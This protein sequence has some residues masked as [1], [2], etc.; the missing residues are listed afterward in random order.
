MGEGVLIGLPDIFFERDGELWCE[1]VSLS[2]IGREVGTPC[3]VYSETGIRRR[4]DALRSAFTGVPCRIFYSAKANANLAILR[5]LRS[6]GAGVDVVSQGELFRARCAGFQAR[7]IVFGGVGKTAQELGAGLEAEILL[8]NVESEGELRRL[9]GLAAARGARAPV[10]IR[11]NPGMAVDTHAYTQTAHYETKFGVAWEDVEDLYRLALRLG[12]VDPLGIDFHLGSQILSPE[13]YRRALPRLM[14]LAGR[15]ARTGASLRYLDIGGGFGVPH[16]G[17]PE[18]DL[19]A[20]AEAAGAAAKALDVEILLEPGRWLVAPAGVLLAG[21]LYAKRLG[22]RLYYVTDA[23][24]NDLLRPSY[25]GA[26]HPIEAVR[27]GP[28]TTVA[29]IVGPVCETGDFLGRDRPMPALQEGDFLAVGFA[30]GYGFAMSSNYNARRRAAEVLVSAD[31]YR[32]VRR[33]ESLADLVA[34]E[35]PCEAG[36]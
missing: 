6:L 35:E 14:E 25:Y 9:S 31:G 18:L 13:P 8:F 10:A 2:R 34:L 4:Y 27:R 24:S 1:G 5:L 11:V 26:Y 33:R 30:G 22:G 16:D 23:G 21:V 19:S 28:A 7:D 20:V 15:V 3:Y 17:G 29:D 36:P 12:S 32:V